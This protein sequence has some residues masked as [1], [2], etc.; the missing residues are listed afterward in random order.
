MTTL[1]R[2]INE[3]DK[4]LIQL[5]ETIIQGEKVKEISLQFY[6]I[7]KEFLLIETSNIQQSFNSS[8]SNELQEKI[9]K[10]KKNIEI[11]EEY[12]QLKNNEGMNNTL[13]TLTYLNTLFLPLGLITG[14]FGMNFIELGNPPTKSNKK[15]IFAIQNPN[16]FIGILF[17]ISIIATYF[18]MKY[19][20]RFK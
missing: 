12:I 7:K 4:Q 3:I 5:D 1:E 20:P 8:V 16:V 2:K 11:I 19:I 17:I 13:D 18:V 9:K 6:K 15:A 14:Y 10:T